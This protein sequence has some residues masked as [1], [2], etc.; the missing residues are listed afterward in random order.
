MIIT[1]DWVVVLSKHLKNDQ[2]RESAIVQ[3]YLIKN[4]QFLK[5]LTQSLICDNKQPVI[6]ETQATVSAKERLQENFPGIYFQVQVKILAE[7]QTF[8]WKYLDRISNI[9]CEMHVEWD[10]L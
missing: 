8:G 9:K 4:I 2:E 10:T 7:R 5:S 3:W 1:Q 6:S